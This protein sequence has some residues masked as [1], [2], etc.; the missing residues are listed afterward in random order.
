LSATTQW[1][2]R[3]SRGSGFSISGFAPALT[4]AFR[5]SH[6]GNCRVSRQDA[7]V[8]RPVRRLCVAILVRVTVHV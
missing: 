3:R 7:A 2:N 1:R 4:P 8:Q 6:K 5:I